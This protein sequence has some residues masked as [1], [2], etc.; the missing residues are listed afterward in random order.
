MLGQALRLV[1][2]AF[3]VALG[4]TSPVL[5]HEPLWGETP[6]IFGPGVIHPEIKI[7]FVRAGGTLDPGDTR[8]RAIEQEYGLQYGI[9][10]FVNVQ[11]ML[12]VSSMVLDENIAGA[13]LRT[14]V[15]GVGSAM[16]RAKYRIHLRQETGF[17]TAQTII[18]G[19]K[20]PTGSDQ[21][22]GPD[23]SRLLPEDQPGSAGH[24]IEVGYAY[25]RE[26]LADSLWA[27]L[28]YDHEFGQGFRRGDTGELDASYGWWL[29][30][31]NVAEQLGV[32]FAV[33][34]H[35]EASASDRLESGVSARTAH[36][37]AGIH[38]TPIITKGQ[39]Q[40]RVGLFVPIVKGGN[41]EQTDFGYEIRAG[42]EMFF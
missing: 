36:S 23:G 31:P 11:I 10:R 6:V 3:G 27:S 9:N 24:G 1:A 4:T 25:D 37:V 30:R 42:W 5:A 26:H 34:L 39:Y 16:L 29:L 19:W 7:R 32:N 13:V 14:R 21:R 33:G 18:A 17:Q 12:P 2:G 35:A 40:Y 41:K 20:I 15:S 22:T 28:F 8:S 38:L